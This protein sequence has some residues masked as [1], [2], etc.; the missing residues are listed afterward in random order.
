MTIPFS[1]VGFIWA[2]Q[3]VFHIGLPCGQLLHPRVPVGAAWPM[4]SFRDTVLHSLFHLSTKAEGFLL[5]SGSGSEIHTHLPIPLHSAEFLFE[6]S[7]LRQLSPISEA[8][9]WCLQATMD[10]QGREGLR[11]LLLSSSVTGKPAALKCLH[12]V[13]L[14]QVKSLFSVCEHCTP[15]DSVW[16]E[17]KLRPLVCPSSLA[18]LLCQGTSPVPSGFC[19]GVWRGVG[20]LPASQGLLIKVFGGYQHCKDSAAPSHTEFKMQQQAYQ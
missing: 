5:P 8:S 12:G 19:L 15:K 4:L 6:S 17:V 18:G 1:Q 9:T 3:S 13:L 7:C 11:D 14:A 20:N 10:S 2:W 16:G